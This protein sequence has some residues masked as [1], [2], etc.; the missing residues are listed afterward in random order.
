MATK[1]PASP[2]G[3]SSSA[4]ASSSGGPSTHLVKRSRVED[5]EM[6]GGDASTSLIPISSSGSG[7][8]DKGLMRAVKRT[9]GL[10]HPILSLSGGHSGEILDVRFS[11]DGDYIAAAGGDR[12]VSIWK[13]YAPNNHVT[14]LSSHRKAVTCLAFLPRNPASSASRSPFEPQL[15]SGP[16]LLSGSADST[17]ILWSPLSPPPSN[18]V[19]R[20]RH[21][22]AIVN[23]VAP[24]PSDAT[25]FASGSDDGDICIWK[26]DEKKPWE[27]LKVGYPVTAIEWT[28]DGSGL[29]VGG[30]DNRIHLYD[31]HRKEIIYSLESHTDTITSL[32]LSPSGSHL[33]SFSLDS[34]LKVWDVRPFAVSSGADGDG[35]GAEERLQGSYS[36]AVA[37]TDSVLIK[38]GWSRDGKRIVCGSGDRTC[39]VWDV[40]LAGKILYKLP[41]HRGTCT[42][43]ALHPREPIVVSCSVD[44]QLLLGEIEGQ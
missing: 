16:L 15:P 26:I 18:K 40:E 5:E 39:V 37:G 35:D 28:K 4:T 34:S 31:L 13:T 2:L 19:R 30:L 27:V 23:C 6:D 43:A 17:L 9:S 20:F 38:A 7:G 3:V 36:G 33:L 41:G 25:L 11:E 44:G 42:A 24:A 29:F 8:K 22:R 21:H 1:R 12:T 14:S 10:S 32:R